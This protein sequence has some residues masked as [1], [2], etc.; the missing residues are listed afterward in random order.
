ML[1]YSQ[2]PSERICDCKSFIPSLNKSHTCSLFA[3]GQRA[4]HP[5]PLQTN[6]A[7]AKHS[8]THIYWHFITRNILA[9]VH[10]QTHTWT[11]PCWE[12]RHTHTHITLTSVNRHRKMCVY[13]QLML[14]TPLHTPT[15]RKTSPSSCEIKLLFQIRHVEKSLEWLTRHKSARLFFWSLISFIYFF[16][17][18]WGFPIKT[19]S[20]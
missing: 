15:F 9:R 13:K 6:T 20:P 11:Q 14:F 7:A 5:F 10:K 12:S 1:L 19:N 4:F 3:I 2:H 18:S 17:P 16:F 8:C